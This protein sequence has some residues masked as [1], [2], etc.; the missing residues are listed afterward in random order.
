MLI[1]IIAM[2]PFTMYFNFAS[3]FFMSKGFTQVTAIMSW[4]Q[5]AEMAIM[6]LVPIALTRYGAKWAITA[7]LGALVVRYIA[8]LAGGMLNQEWL[9]Y[10]AILVHGAIFG[11]LIVGGQV[12]VDKKAP[13]EIK[14]QAQGLVGLLLFGVG[15]LI[16]T[17]GSEHLINMCTTEKMVENVMTK[18]TNWN[19]VWFIMMALSAVLMAAFGALFRDDVT[20]KAAAPAL[21]ASTN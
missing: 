12:Y 10:I 9:Y 14:A 16:G 15:M 11:L 2:T 20:Q 4:G 17:F 6:L 21:A 19:T 18:V 8:F 7:G 3:Q 1:S 5:I 13:P